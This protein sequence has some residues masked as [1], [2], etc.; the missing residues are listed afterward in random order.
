MKKEKNRSA[1]GNMDE[2]RNE[3]TKLPNTDSI[4][5]PA[6]KEAIKKNKKR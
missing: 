4:S 1:T 3:G 2:G 6:T 5:V